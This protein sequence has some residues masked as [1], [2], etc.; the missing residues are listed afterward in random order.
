VVSIMGVDSLVGEPLQSGE[1]AEDP[2]GGNYRL[3]VLPTLQVA[4]CA[5]L[6]DMLS[7]LPSIAP[8]EYVDG[9]MH[10]LASSVAFIERMSINEGALLPTANAAACC[11]GIA[12]HEVLKAASR[13]GLG[14]PFTSQFLLF[15]EKKQEEKKA[16]FMQSLL[17]GKKQKKKEIADSRVFVVGCGAT[18]CELLKNLAM[19]GAGSVVA[20]DDDSVE[21]SNLARQ[22]LFRSSDVGKS[23]A[24]TA[25]SRAQDLGTV[26]KFEA[27]ERRLDASSTGPGGP[28]NAE[29]FAGVD[30]VFSA[31]D[32]V[33]ARLFV[34]SLCL[35]YKVPMVDCGT[36]G[37][38]GSVQAVVPDLTESYGA[39]SDPEAPCL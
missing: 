14:S 2:V 30:C 11:G 35:K 24:T 4:R 38:S 5:S 37:A 20:T 16:G 3:N 39:A 36:L 19:V 8:P 33:Q 27:H 13:G 25:C 31:L 10:K 32:N 6:R 15:E 28:F 23:K 9:E 21:V 34:D 22:F 26:T 29:F 18:G 7:R 17:L 1:G 12:A